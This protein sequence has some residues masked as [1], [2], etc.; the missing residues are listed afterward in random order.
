MAVGLVLFL[1][2]FASVGWWIP[3]GVTAAVLA[4]LAVRKVFDKRVGVNYQT[5]HVTWRF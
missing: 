1:A 4:L 3:A 2:L 5:G